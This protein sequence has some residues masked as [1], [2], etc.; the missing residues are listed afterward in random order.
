[1]FLQFSRATAKAFI[2]SVSNCVTPFKASLMTPMRVSMVTKTGG[3]SHQSWR[4]LGVN[5]SLGT[6][7]FFDYLEAGPEALTKL[8]ACRLPTK[9]GFEGG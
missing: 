3:L 7:N 8:N 6:K 9:G 5:E 4:A 1:V 2:S